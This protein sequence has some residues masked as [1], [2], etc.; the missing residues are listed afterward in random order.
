MAESEKRIEKGE[1]IIGIAIILAALLLCATAYVSTSNLQAAIGKINVGAAQATAD[2]GTGSNTGTTAP[3][4][5]LNST[6][7]EQ[8]LTNNFLAAQGFSAKVTS[9]VP[10]SDEIST[11]T[12]SIMNGTS[13]LQSGFTFYA[14]NDGKTLMMGGQAYNTNETVP[15]AQAPSPGQVQ[16]AAAPSGNWSYISSLPYTGPANASVTV[17][18]FTDPQCPYCEI[19]EGRE[20]GGSNLDALRGVIPKIVS[21]Y[22]DTGKAKIV[23]NIMAFLGQESSDAANAEYCARNISGDS[24]FITMHNKL[25]AVHTGSEDVG[26]YSKANLIKYAAEVGFNSTAM[27]AC[28]N[29]GAYDSFV[30]QTTAQANA[31]GV[32]STPTIAV[33]NKVV[34]DPTYAAVKAAIDQ[35]IA[36]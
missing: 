1:Y 14:T 6:A 3:A 17:V 8:Y 29:N 23:Y 2:A 26:T 28:I 34:S 19:A 22:A 4:A 10:Y 33:N 13:V 20:F 25:V 16:P 35:A 21:E 30:S 31:L 5:K 9:V 12:V 7:I 27:A 32:Q 24:G 15:K 36:G 11:V 18:L